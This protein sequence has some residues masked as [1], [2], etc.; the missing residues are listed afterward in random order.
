[1]YVRCKLFCECGD[2][3][4]SVCVHV[5]M[6]VLLASNI[7]ADGK[8]P[9]NTVYIILVECIFPLPNVHPFII[10]SCSVNRYFC[11]SEIIAQRVSCSIWHVLSVCPSVNFL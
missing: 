7:Q 9:Q 10:H 11:M 5:R 3:Y 1:M 4:T 8:F 2:K 6:C